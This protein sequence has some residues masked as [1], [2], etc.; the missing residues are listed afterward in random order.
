MTAS[1][2]VP[3][4]RSDA[5]ELRLYLTVPE[6][7]RLAYGV[8]SRRAYALA[9]RGVLPTVR[10]GRLLKVPVGVLSEIA[11]RDADRALAAA[12]ARTTEAPA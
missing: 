3:A 5:A 1:T 8:G 9:A 6:A 7:G 11:A 2:P 10:V 4:T 12:E